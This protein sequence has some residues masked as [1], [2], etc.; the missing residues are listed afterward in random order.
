MKDKGATIILSTHQLNQVQEICERIL[1][2]DN[3]KEA[4][5]GNLDEIRYSYYGHSVIIRTHDQIP[6]IPGIRSIEPING[7]YQINLEENTT[8]EHVLKQ[9]VNMDVKLESFQ[10]AIPSLDE[11]FIRAVQGNKKNS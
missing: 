4:L 9:L 7:E 6:N 10:F 3:G 5:H 1:L 2:M 8:P 11:I